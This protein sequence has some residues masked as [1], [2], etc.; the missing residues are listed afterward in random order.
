MFWKHSQV[1]RAGGEVS[2][3]LKYFSERIPATFVYAGINL[4]TSEFMA[5]TRGA[6]IAG[7]FTLVPTRPFP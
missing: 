4:D 2:D 5:G 3:T 1:T 6:Q 7:R